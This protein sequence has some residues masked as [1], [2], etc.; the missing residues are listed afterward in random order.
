MTK[1]S[2][3]E[4]VK[5][6]RGDVDRRRWRAGRDP[7]WLRRVA[8]VTVEPYPENPRQHLYTILPMPRSQNDS[9]NDGVETTRVE[10]TPVQKSTASEVKNLHVKNLHVKEV[11]PN[12]KRNVEEETNEEEENGKTDSSTTEELDF[13]EVALHK[14]FQRYLAAG[15]WSGPHAPTFT[16]EEIELVNESGLTK[17][18]ARKATKAGLW[19]PGEHR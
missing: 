8:L 4:G 6:L 7:E 18:E 14:R 2:V 9:E 12:K 16:A 5:E 13:V 1:K 3:I 10:T 19:P 17:I 15:G 11:H